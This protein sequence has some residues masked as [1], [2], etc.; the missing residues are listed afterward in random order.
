M[1]LR[2]TFSNSK[3]RYKILIKKKRS[4]N[5]QY[6]RKTKKLFNTIVKRFQGGAFVVQFQAETCT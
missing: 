2:V 6:L 4:G 3:Y 5:E 1:P